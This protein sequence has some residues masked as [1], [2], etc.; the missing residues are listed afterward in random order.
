[1]DL[2]YFEKAAKSLTEFSKLND[3]KCVGVMGGEPTLH[4]QFPEICEIFKSA[5]PEK[6][7]RGLW[8]N[9]LTSQFKLHTNIIAD[10]FGAFNLNDHT[11][12]PIKHTPILTAIEDFKDLTEDEKLKFIDNCWVQNYWSATINMKGAFFC[13]VCACMSNL[14]NGINGW[15]IEENPDWWKKELPEYKDQINWACKKCGCCLPLKP[16]RSNEEI[17]DI[18]ISNIERLIDVKSPKIIKGK[19]EVVECSK[20]I[21]DPTQKRNTA[22]YW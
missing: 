12:N 11:S 13:E 18:S 6:R 5:I 15:N 17:D 2:D 1:M 14:F 8:S 21:L 10:T 9:T 3:N 22:W 20:N 16:R 7:K 4:P 19:F